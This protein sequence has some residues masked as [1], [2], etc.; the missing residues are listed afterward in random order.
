MSNYITVAEAA[1]ILGLSQKTIRR[2][3]DTLSNDLST[4]VQKD[5]HRILIDKRLV[6]GNFKRLEGEDQTTKKTAEKQRKNGNKTST[7]DEKTT[8]NDKTETGEKQ[9]IGAN[10]LVPIFHQQLNE[11]DKQ[12]EALTER[13]R[14]LTIIIG[15][16]QAQQEKLLIET[17]KDTQP[18]TEPNKI[19]SNTASN[20]SG[21]YFVIFALTALLILFVVY[22]LINGI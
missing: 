2:R 18:T 14:E 19:P 21:L 17:A 4:Y 12:I 11:K 9:G 10:E 7:N 8:L 20:Q 22:M 15:R 5:G 6:L 3:L 1:K 13:N 16:M